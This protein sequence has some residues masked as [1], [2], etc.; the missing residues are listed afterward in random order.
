M[1]QITLY[2]PRDADGKVK[3]A[4]VDVPSVPRIGEYADHSPSGIAGYVTAVTYWW[5][6]PTAPVDIQVQVK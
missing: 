6:G 5:G 4:V 3:E 1:I 2:G